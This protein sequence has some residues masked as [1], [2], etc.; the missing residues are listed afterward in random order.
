MEY[1]IKIF[2]RCIQETLKYFK[3]TL[4]LSFKESALSLQGAD[5][6]VFYLYKGENK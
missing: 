3:K 5:R 4:F 2:V 1:L 6:S